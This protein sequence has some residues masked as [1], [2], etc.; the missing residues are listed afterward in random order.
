MPLNEQKVQESIYAFLK[1]TLDIFNLIK[2]YSILI[3][4]KLPDHKAPVHAANELKSLV[5][6]LYNT[7]SFPEHVE[8]NILEAKEHLCRAFYDLHCITISLFIE[9]IKDKI[10][11]YKITT[12]ANAFPEYGSI[13]RPAIRNIQEQLRDIRTNRNTDTTL[14]NVDIDTF[15]EQVRTMA[16]FDDIVES[17]KPVLNRYDEEKE[18]EERRREEKDKRKRH[19]DKIWDIAKIVIGAAIGAVITW[20]IKSNKSS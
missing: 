15:S 11:C 2:K 9:E 20:L 3:E 6:H 12:V 17:M 19:K 16:R 5:F 8:I 7:I 4:E 14:L 13:I 1:E 18:E 10:S